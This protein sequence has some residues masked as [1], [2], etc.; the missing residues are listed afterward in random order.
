MSADHS[1]GNAPDT[2]TAAK[3]R[4]WY[5]SAI[6][7]LLCAGLMLSMTLPAFQSYFLGE[8]FIYLGQYRAAGDSYWGGVWRATD[9]IFFRPVFSAVNLIWMFTL[10]LDPWVH[11]VRNFMGSVVVVLL[12][13]RVLLRLT[14]SRYARAIGVI[15]FAVSK[16]HLTNIGYINCN[17]SVVSLLLMLSALLFWLRF[18]A[19]SKWTDYF[20]AICFS[21]LAIFTKDYGLVVVSVVGTI[22]FFHAIRPGQWRESGGRW[23][24]RLIPLA[25]LVGI[26]LAMR[27][28]I[29]I[30]MPSSSAVYSPML[31]WNQ[32]VHKTTVFVSALG[33][34]SVDTFPSD[35]ATTGARGINDWLVKT[36]PQKGW[37]ADQL[38][39]WAFA[40]FAGLIA[41]TVAAGRR[42]K[43]RLLIG[44]MWIAAYFCPTLLTR[45]LQMYYMYE[46]L[47]GAV[48]LLA[49]CLDRCGWFVRILWAPALI[50]VTLNGHLSNQS[51]LY[52]WQF[53]ARGTGQI[54]KPV[55]DAFRDKPLK[56]MTFLSANP[57]HWRWALAAGGIGPMVPELLHQPNLD[58]RFI[59]YESAAQLQGKVDDQHVVIDID[60]GMIRYDPANKPPAPVLEAL[61]PNFILVGVGCNL[62]QNG[63]SAIAIRAKNASP[64]TVL[65]VDGQ[66]LATTRAS[67]TYLTALVPK[68]LV[69]RAGRHSAYLSSWTGDSAQLD[70]V[71]GTEEDRAQLEAE[72][73]QPADRPLR[74]ISLHPAQTEAG[75]GF[76][77]QPDGGSGI[78][79]VCE[80]ALMGTV[81]IVDGTPLVTSYG[82]DS[83]LTAVIP[84]SMLERPGSY[85]VV[86]RYGRSESNPVSFVITRAKGP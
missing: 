79:V 67:D 13:H 58:V 1:G 82:G 48:V 16:I 68:G 17:D 53:A 18:S 66:R 6:I 56:S 34:L 77:V 19:T 40:G 9:N 78:G 26:Y 70:L 86:L 64:A 69:D 54:E 55:I 14:Q 75:A 61:E 44:S 73:E 37:N 83:M 31:L 81:I 84:P 47:A 50:L 72:R 8:D 51:S 36:Y 5:E 74:L 41:L 3:R 35:F 52:H 7:T 65:V 2:D 39:W 29:V 33:N 76:N 38:E 32:S 24:V 30:A 21:G 25:L 15:L 80:N 63:D 62:Q 20:A 4:G 12:L 71:V 43:W 42:A 46:P 28:T 11:H 45:N 85:K 23:V 27:S 22:A 57:E 10:K 59:G 60:N 49:L